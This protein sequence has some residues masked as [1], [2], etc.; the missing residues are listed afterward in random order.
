MPPASPL[1]LADGFGDLPP[2]I[3]DLG[4]VSIRRSFFRYAC[5]IVAIEFNQLPCGPSHSFQHRNLFS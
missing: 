5:G 2:N 3:C 1:E 4:L